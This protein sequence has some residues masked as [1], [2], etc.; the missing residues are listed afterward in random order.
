MIV[1]LELSKNIITPN[2]V[3]LSR[4][5]TKTISDLIEF[6]RLSNSYGERKF[7]TIIDDNKIDNNFTSLVDLAFGLGCEYLLFKGFLKG[8]K[9][10]KVIRYS[11]IIEE[12]R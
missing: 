4:V 1:D 2:V 12:L 8:E 3:N 11:E 5:N 6:N 9:L 10:A 7:S